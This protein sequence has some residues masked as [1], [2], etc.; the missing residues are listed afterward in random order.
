MKNVLKIA[1]IA[2]VFGAMFSV[3]ASANEVLLT[4]SEAKSSAGAMALDLVTDGNVTAFEFTVS[5]NGA[6]SVDTSKCLSEL[7]KSHNGTCVFRAKTNDVIVIAF[8]PTNA[9]LPSGVVGL[10]SLNL[11]AASAAK[12]GVRA[13]NVVFAG[14]DG[15]EIKA[16]RN[17]DSAMPRSE[18]ETLK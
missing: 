13:D 14:V 2:G 6:K 1:T 7:P 18:K 5:A 3:S 15:R 9:P 11:P 4:A 17:A 16:N 12:A 10:G 8:S